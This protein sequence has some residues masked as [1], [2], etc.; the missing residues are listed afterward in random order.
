M[1]G[2]YG[3]FNLDGAPATSDVPRQ[4]ARLTV[5]RG[6]DDEG[7]HCD[8]PMAFGMRRLSIIDVGGGHQPLTNEDATIF[9]VANGEIYNYRALRD[10][11][12]KRGHR[13][14]S[15]SDCETIVHLYEEYGDDCVS[16]LNGMFAFAL[17]DARRARLL[18][19]RDRL[20]VKPLYLCNDGR[21]LLFASEA[22]AMLA[23]PGMAAELD[24]AAVA[25]Y[26]ALG[27]VPAPQSMFRGIR[28]LAPATVL[29][30]ERGRVAER[31]YWSLSSDIDRERSEADWIA[32]VRSALERATHM[33]MVSDVPIGAF[34][35]GGIDSSAVVAFMA[36]HSDRPVQTYA[37]GFGG[38]AAESYYN[39]LPYARRVATLFRTD[40]HEI[41]VKPDVVALLP[42]LLWHMDEPLADTAF[43][44]T[45]LV[46][47]FA[48]RDVTV[49][50]SGVGGDEL[51]GGYRRYLGSHYQAKFQRLPGSVRRI[52]IALSRR[53]PSDRHSALMNASRLAKGF[54]STAGLPLEER[55]R[56][57][58]E[59]FD[60][61]DAARLMRDARSGD[62]DLLAAAFAAATG[63]DEINRMLKVD[64][65]TQLPDD[66]LLLTDKMS[67][68]VSLECRVP[69]LD[70]ELVEL[71]ARMPQDVKIRGGRLKHALKEALAGVL[72]DDILERRKRGFGTPMGAWLKRDLKPMLATML[73]ESAVNAR[74]IFHKR[75]IDELVAGHDSGRIDGTDRLLALL[76]LE[77]W[78]RI[79]LDGRAPEDVSGELKELAA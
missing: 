50:L 64:V 6:P 39:E 7:L 49:I 5:H 56:S 20:G 76:N 16:H 24:P 61:D 29:V 75:A 42:R 38:G 67:M 40:H 15:A 54:L 31:C 77:I 68:A 71:A 43:I 51:F 57:Y 1:C 22:K 62:D 79:Y 25:S 53:L 47:E 73:S 41:L 70:H 66:L 46:S 23:V 17:W 3:V 19:A 45:Y 36:A 11:L 18:I 34:L 8:G 72:P 26:L 9:L 30:A 4:M 37:I 44:T 60:R 14:R 10:E 74:G 28:K 58:V 33:Q 21:R 32:Q 65:A 48:R 27:Y 2:I 12:Q 78:A 52:A 13:F 63:S 69:F 59:V 35:S 55:Y